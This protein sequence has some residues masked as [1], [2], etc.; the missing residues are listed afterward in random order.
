MVVLKPVKNKVSKLLLISLFLFII[1]RLTKLLA[2]KFPEEG[3]FY[4][5]ELGLKLF[6]NKN[7]AF[8]LPFE[9]ILTIIL[10]S[11]IIIILI[12]F[13]IKFY[14]TK[15]YIFLGALSLI[16]IGALSNLFDRLRFQAVIDFIDIWFWPAFNFA[17]AYIVIGIFWL[18]W[19]SRK[20]LPKKEL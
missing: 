20:C 18:I 10:S 15:N 13:W 9:Q 2:L 4:Y 19:L 17:D 14:K 8:S 7:L 3:F 5:K 12:Y 16:I 6:L 1:D 11:L